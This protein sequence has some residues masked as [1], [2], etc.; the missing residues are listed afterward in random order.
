[1]KTK[2]RP[3]PAKPILLGGYVHPAVARGFRALAKE[4]GRTV[5]GMLSKLIPSILAQNGY[6]PATGEKR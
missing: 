3:Q 2:N 4:D 6:D 5:S 1:M